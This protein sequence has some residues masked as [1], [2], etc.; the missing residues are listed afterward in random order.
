MTDPDFCPYAT[1]TFHTKAPPHRWWSSEGFHHTKAFGP[2]ARFRCSSCGR[3]F[4][5]QT[6]SPHYYAKRVIDLQQLER[7]SASSMG[8]RALSRQFACSCGTVTNRIDR[9]ARQGIGLHSK[10]RKLADPHEP[11]S[12]DDF[13]SF[14]RSQY[15]PSNIGISMTGTSR[16]ALGLSHAAVKRSGSMRE[17]QKQ[18]R[19]KLY[20]GLKFE[21]KAVER[22][23]REHLD[24]LKRERLIGTANPLIIYSDEKKE[25]ARA[26]RKHELFTRQD[27]GRRCFHVTVNSKEP[28]TVH[29]PLFPS[30]YIDREIRKDQANHRRESTCFSRSPA[31]TMSRLHAYLVW[32]NYHKLYLVKA[33]VDSTETHAEVAGIQ[34]TAIDSSRAAMFSRRAFLSLL[35]LDSLDLKIW[36]KTAYSAEEGKDTGAVL[37]KFAFG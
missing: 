15:F 18:H 6:F 36:T 7:L 19:D 37:P 33:P 25:Y 8:T 22:S 30:N 16:F 3:T 4:S 31:N 1:C 21:R 17:D 5:V 2:V 20:E 14:D 24:R 28:R 9:I 32:H 23:F 35:D 10:L 12:Y 27:E 13:V 11:F 29:N 34:R 26:F